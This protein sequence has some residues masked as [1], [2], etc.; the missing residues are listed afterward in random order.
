MVGCLLSIGGSSDDESSRHIISE[1]QTACFNEP[2]VED[3]GVIVV[4]YDSFAFSQK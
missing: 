4:E 3:E 2:V 1:S